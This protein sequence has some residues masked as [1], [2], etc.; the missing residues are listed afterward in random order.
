[1]KRKYGVILMD[2]EQLGN[3]KVSSRVKKAIQVSNKKEIGE[4]KGAN[5]IITRNI[6]FVEDILNGGYEAAY[7]INVDDKESMEEAAN[8]KAPINY[9]I[10]EFKDT[11][12]IPLELILAKLQNKKITVLKMVETAQAGTVAMGVMEIGSDGVI[13]KTKDVGELV[14]LAQSTRDMQKGKLE[15]SEAEIIK[16]THLEMGERACVDTTSIMTKE[17]GMIVGSTSKGGLYMCSETHYLPY[18][19]QRAFRVNA[20]AVHSYIWGPNN[21]VQYMTDLKAGEKLLCVNTKGETRIVNVGRIKIEVRQL[22][23][24]EAK[25]GDVKINTIVQDDWHIRLFG[26]GGKVINV[27]TLKPGDKVLAHVCDSGRHV[28]L[29][30]EE[31]IVE[32]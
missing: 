9:L 23:M 27:T 12:N 28:G 30:I 4:M 3:I 14:T 22:L 7:Y 19:N 29:K 15:L 26:V 21:F 1:M 24:I 17:E 32:N 16:I 6:E 8:I 13:L 2:K 11:T 31:T 18:M 5:I 10:I 25:V 20:G